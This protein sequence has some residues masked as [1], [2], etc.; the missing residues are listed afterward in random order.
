LAGCDLNRKWTTPSEI[1]HPEIYFTKNMI[2]KNSQK[3]QIALICDLHGHSDKFNIFM[4][5]NKVE[6][7]PLACKL[8]PYILSKVN[9]TFF[10]N[11]CN[12]KMQKSKKTTARINL[13]EVLNE[14]PNVFTMEAS[15]AG[16]NFVRLLFI[17]I[18]F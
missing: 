6:Q 11:Y 3:R 15:F 4:Y 1:L 2:L 7:S 18:F 8:Y 9:N 10:Y 16:Q 12:F 13:F 14:I 17:Q 5:G